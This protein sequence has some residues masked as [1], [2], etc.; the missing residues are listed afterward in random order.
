ME[1]M[2]TPST[3][4]H[5]E[6]QTGQTDLLIPID[7]GLRNAWQWLAMITMLL[8][9]LGYLYYDL[10]AFRYIGRLGMPLYAMLFVMSMQSGRINHKRLLIIAMISQ[11]PYLLIFTDPQVLKDLYFNIIFGFYVFYWMTVAVKHRSWLG[12]AAVFAAMWIPVAYCWYLY[13]SMAAFYWLDHKPHAKNSVFAIATVV[14][15]YL[16][17]THLRQ[18]LAIL[19]PLIQGIK[20]PRPPKYL[21]RYFYPGHL[22]ILLIIDFMII[23]VVYTPFGTFPKPTDDTESQWYNEYYDENAPVEMYEKEESL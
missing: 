2:I 8:D 17:D 19:A 12:I 9:H 6:S 7:N 4:T 16:T 5:N 22:F 14:Y 1:P 3:V 18:L 11:I 15:T 13:A 20:A 21:Y 23:G 10:I